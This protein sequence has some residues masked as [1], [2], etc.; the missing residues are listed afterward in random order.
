M[1]QHEG[2]AGSLVCIHHWIIAQPAGPTSRGRC[3]LCKE[4]RDFI[5]AEEEWPSKRRQCKGCGESYPPRPEFFEPYGLSMRLHYRCRE[6][7]RRS[8]ERK[9]RARVAAGVAA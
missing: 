9:V 7:R 6:C 2:V 8:R 5:N 1:V 4:E 3:K